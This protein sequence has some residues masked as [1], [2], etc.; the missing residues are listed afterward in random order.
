MRQSCWLPRAW[1]GRRKRL[2]AK[3]SSAAPRRR[4]SYRGGWQKRYEASTLPSSLWGT[5]PFGMGES[6]FTLRAQDLAPL[7]PRQT[8]L[9]ERSPRLPPDQASKFS[10]LSSHCDQ[11]YGF[12][13]PGLPQIQGSP[14]ASAF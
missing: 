9:S 11:L 3:S 2:L 13:A 6:A 5:H 4:A 14:P 1:C 8:R 10:L 12:K 7:L